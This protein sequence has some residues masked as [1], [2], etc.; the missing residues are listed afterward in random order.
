MKRAFKRRLPPVV[1]YHAVCQR[2]TGG[3]DESR[4]L[5]VEPQEFETHMS[6]LVRQGYKTLRLDQF[7]AIVAGAP[8]PPRSLLLTFDDAYAHLHESVSPLLARW[9]LSAVV[10]A[11]LAALGRRN[12]WDRGTAVEG[13]Q[14]ASAALLR[15]MRKYRWEVGSHA[16]DH[17][18]LRRMD[19][20]RLRSDLAAAREE[21]GALTGAEVLDLAYPYGYNDANVREAARRSG[22]RMAFTVKKGETTD[23]FQLPSHSV[24]GEDGSLAFSLAIRPGTNAWLQLLRDA[25]PGPVRGSLRALVRRLNPAVVGGD[26]HHS[27]G[28]AGDGVTSPKGVCR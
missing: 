19:P 14:V 8:A 27:A 24:N 11:S 7:A 12:T 1:L 22:H 26:T 9:N 17:V 23:P 4:G 21:L 6:G 10:F 15:Q 3:A 2:P 5:I 25:A 28:A 20:E 13:M 18:D 16:Y